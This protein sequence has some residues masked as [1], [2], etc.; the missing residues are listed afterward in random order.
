MSSSTTPKT[1]LLRG[2]QRI[3]LEAQAATS[4][5]IKPGM[6]I[7]RTSAGT[8]QKH[9]SSP[10]RAPALFAKEADYAGKS[11]DDAYADGDVVPFYHCQPGDVVYAWLQAGDDV[12]VGAALQSAGDGSLE[13][14]D[15]DGH[16]VATALEAV[17]N[18]PGSGGLPVR[19]KVEIN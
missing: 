6:L 7:E 16:A 15:S 17:D 2:D 3:A 10:G 1:I 18:N 13:A 9:V 12:A 5:A 19:I 8:V 14:V 4:A 11:I